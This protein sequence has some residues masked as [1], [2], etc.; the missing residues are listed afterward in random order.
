MTRPGNRLR[1]CAARVFDAHTMERL[2]D[3]VIAD[4]QVEYAEAVQAGPNWRRRLVRFRGYVAVVKV[5]TRTLQAFLAVAFVLMLLLEVPAFSNMRFTLARA[6]YLVP[7][8]LVVAIPIA[9]TLMIAWIGSAA[10]SRRSRNAMLFAGVVCSL[11]AFVLFGWGIPAANQSFRVSMARENGLSFAP[12]RAPAELT[13]GELHKQ[14]REARAVGADWRILGF[15][16]HQ[17]FAFAFASLALT[18]LMGALRRCGSTRLSMLLGAVPIIVGYYTLIWV[19]RE[20]AIAGPSIATASPAAGA[21]MPNVITVLTAAA[22]AA[23]GSRRQ[24]VA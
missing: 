22:F 24:A 8:A 21:W 11:V 12:R 19:G 3:P 9:L 2:I 15:S 10:R 6:V 17:R 7:Q 14:M 16:F 5:A 20:Y 13:I 4:L 1:A 23:M 18:I